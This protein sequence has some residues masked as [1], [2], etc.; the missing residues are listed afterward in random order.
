MGFP[1][2]VSQ[3]TCVAVGELLGRATELESIGAFVERSK[4]GPADLVIEGEA[5]IG[6]TTV[7]REALRLAENCGIRVLSCR[8]AETEAKLSFAGLAD[9]L[10]P[11]PDEALDSLPGPQRRALDVA[12]LRTDPEGAAPDP[13][14]VATAF[15]SV[16]MWLGTSPTLVAIDDAHWLDRSSA[17]AIEFAF[18]RRGDSKLALLASCRP[19][20][21]VLAAVLSDADRVDLGPLSLGAVHELVKGRLG[22]SLPRPLLMRIYESAHGNPFYVLEISREVLHVALEPGDP[23][24]VPRTL[25]QLIQR[26]IARLPKSTRDALL[27]AAIVAQPDY[28]IVVDA[29]GSGAWT[30][31]ERAE[32]AGIVET[33][34]DSLR[35]SHPLFAAAVQAAAPGPRRRQMHRVVAE[36]IDEPEARALHLALAAEGPDELVASALDHAAAAAKKRGALDA[37]VELAE[38]AVRLTP[39]ESAEE[40]AERNLSLG[41]ALRLTGDTDR[42]REVLSALAARTAG[43]LRARAL[44]ELAAVRFWTE[45][46]RAGVESCEQALE[47]ARGDIALE[48]KALADLAVYGEMDLERA[49]RHA[50]HA[51]RLF[52]QQGDDADPLSHAEA[53]A[54]A[55]RSN[56]MLGR[57]LRRHDVDRA[58]ELESKAEDRGEAVVGRTST[59][60]GQWLKYT[61]D[62]DGAREQLEAARQAAVEEGDESALPNILVHLSQTELWGGNWQLAIRYAE[63]SCDIAEQLGQTY[64]GPPA[65]RAHVDA[66]LGHVERARRTAIDGLEAASPGS[67]ASVFHLRA[68]GFLDLSLSDVVSA[69]RHL[70]RAM[71]LMEEARLLEPAVLRIHA[72]AV[73]ALVGVGKLEEAQGVLAFWEKQVMV[74]GY[75]WSLATSARCRAILHAARGR[76]DDALGEVERAVAAH[77]W[78][79]MP[80]ELG[81]TLLARGQIER[82]AKQKGTAKESLEQALAIF[83][84]LPAPL[85]AEKAGNELARVGLRRSSGE[86]TETER[87]VAELAASGLTNREVAAQLFLSPKT[88]EA[89]LARAYRKLGIHS[90][91]ELGA[92]LGRGG[93]RAAQ[94]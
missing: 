80:F 93:S 18:R 65:Q 62:L 1:R 73:E 94:T 48:A 23:L 51:L 22:R 76:S 69:E 40:A 49:L 55:A 83:E 81:R 15:R 19:S 36:V 28:N 88:V 37:V 57:G 53:L 64:G 58:I 86:L 39:P 6:K 84:R 21:A 20:S 82:R 29:L 27:I 35:F 17:S 12:L 25:S 60:L 31:L 34:G 41:I 11:V 72:D 85:W 33:A 26:R 14:A 43:P 59:A 79:G 44:V 75:P 70:T 30:A 5:G 4:S 45:G 90:R 42:A 92:R 38:H 77:E 89:N 63:E 68:L 47:A 71:R 9:L 74:V 56:L 3:S 13:R 78:L 66:H 10:E 61:D 91:A 8:G 87:R 2:V 50:Q 52:E 46:A 24:P 54:A 7:W 32:H 67:L 16:L